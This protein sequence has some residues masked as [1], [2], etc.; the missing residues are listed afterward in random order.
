[1]TIMTILPALATF[2]VG[3]ILIKYPASISMPTNRGMHKDA[4]ASSG[5]IALMAGLGIIS[6]SQS[7]SHGLL[8]SLLLIGILGFFDDKYSLTKYARF[9]FQIGVSGY[10]VYD[11]FGYD[12]SFIYL[13]ILVFIST[14]TINIYNFMDGIDQLA[15]SQAI[16]FIIGWLFIYNT[17]T[18]DIMISILF[19]LMA[20]SLINYPRTKLF[21]G[22]SGSYFLGFLI[23]IIMFQTIFYKGFMGAIPLVILMTTFYTDTTYT[24]VI[25]F[26]RKFNEKSSS[27]IKS[28]NYVTEAHCTHSYQKLAIKKNS[29]SK[30]VFIIMSYSIVWCLPL[31]F[32]ATYH[33]E[34]SLI[35]LILSYLPYIYY[36]YNNK[37]GMES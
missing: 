4:I 24:L 36:C 12:I 18:E 32:L 16:F 15:I 31:S 14:Y 34:Y 37:A 1:M 21:L 22:N 11:Q 7:L 8:A 33:T 20:F 30:V 10:L 23:V 26:I 5:G 9:G 3:Y 35:F 2:I 19:V 17:Y 6:F 13:F 25:R 29:H 27:V 28:I